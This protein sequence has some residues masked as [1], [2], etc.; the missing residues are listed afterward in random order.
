MDLQHFGG[1]AWNSAAFDGSRLAGLA[2]TSLYNLAI[3]LTGRQ[4]VGDYVSIHAGLRAD[5][6]QLFGLEWVPQAG[7]D[8]NLNA[9]TQ[10]KVLFGKGFRNPTIRELFM[11]VPRN[12][13]LQPNAFLIMNALAQNF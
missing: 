4:Q 7:I 3:Y 8:F 12:P 13:D 10:I 9:E 5:K 6:N 11:F 1:E 2:D